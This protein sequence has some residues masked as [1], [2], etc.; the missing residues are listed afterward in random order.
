MINKAIFQIWI[1]SNLFYFFEQVLS[2]LVDFFSPPPPLSGLFPLVVTKAI[3]LRSLIT[4]IFIL[5]KITT[6]L[7]VNK[8]KIK[9]QTPGNMAYCLKGYL[10]FIYSI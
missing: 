2:F 1:N 9:N 5:R 3:C 7:T 10:I 6:Q 8:A 4:L